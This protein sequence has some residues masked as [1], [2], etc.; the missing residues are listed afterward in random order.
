MRQI[1]RTSS[2]DLLCL[3]VLPTHPHVHAL[4]M[5]LGEPREPNLGAGVARLL[6]GLL[7][8]RSSFLGLG[9]LLFLRGLGGGRFR[10]PQGKGI[11]EGGA[12][13]RATRLLRA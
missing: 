5:A 10:P 6:L 3:R 9:A 11:E 13:P 2:T 12:I 4:L 7:G 1:E 8:S